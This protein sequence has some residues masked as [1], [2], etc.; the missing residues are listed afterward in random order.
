M[1]CLLENNPF[2]GTLDPEPLRIKQTELYEYVKSNIPES[3]KQANLDIESSVDNER[4]VLAAAIA[5][6]DILLSDCALG[7]TAEQEDYCRKVQAL[8]FSQAALDFVDVF[9]GAAVALDSMLL[10][11]NSTDVI[12]ALRFFVQ[13]RHFKLPCALS[14]MKRALSLMWSSE[15]IIRDEVSS[16]FVDV[17]IAAPCSD[18]QSDLPDQEIAMNLLALTENASASE[19]ASIEE[20]I[21]RLV[22]EM[23]LPRNVF[24][25]LWLIASKKS[26][27]RVSAFKLLSMGAAADRTFLESKSRLKV[28]LD[29]G[30]LESMRNGNDWELANAV[31]LV[32]QHVGRAVVAQND[33]TYIL[34][35]HI[36]DTLCAIVT[37]ESCVDTNDQD[38]LNWFSPAERAIK[39]LFV[40]CPEPEVICDSIILNMSNTMFE[41]KAEKCNA[42]RLARFFHVLGE[43]GLNLLVY[44]ESLIGSVRRA[45]AKRSL[46][47]QLDAEQSKSKAKASL[48]KTSTPK[49]EDAMESELGMDAAVEA[50]N[51]RKLLDIAENEILGRGIISHFSPLLVYVVADES[52]K[53][54]SEILKQASVL[55]LCKFMCVSSSFC[56]KHLDILF[57]VIS[58]GRSADTTIR[59]NTVV[60]MGDLAFRFPNEFEPYTQR[61][62]SC[63]RDSST[64][65]RRHA[66]MVLTHLILNDMVKVK[67]RVSEIA[68][69]L[70]DA[71]PR[72]RD[73]SRLLFHEL[74]KRSNSPIYNLIPDIVSQLGQLSL[75]KEDF[76]YIMAFLL[77]YINKEKQFEMLTE[78]LCQ[79][80]PGCTSISQKADLAFCISQIKMNEK[81]I[82]C[83]SDNF[84]LYKDALADDDVMKSFVGV[85]SKAKKFVKLEMKEFIEEWETKLIETA[86]TGQENEKVQQNAIAARRKQSRQKQ[87]KELQGN[88]GGIYSDE[89]D[90]D[91]SS[92]S[93]DKEHVL[94]PKSTNI[95]S[96]KGSK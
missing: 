24:K 71:D 96:K 78:K 79:R 30:L 19:L 91:I 25:L 27:H 73:M 44:T 58:N 64:R 51:D 89:V 8:Q 13:A 77:S 63:L 57:S 16:A 4:G 32:L 75:A 22:K 54:S 9:E 31:T 11:A 62:Y 83:L 59:A 37:G 94:R 69:C 15:K 85:V 29:E 2:L 67:G 45:N 52:G 55:A 93:V 87:R 80:F 40:I 12:E 88:D 47:T 90:T 34:L 68:V 26:K 72:I 1:T 10:S 76:R 49:E 81:C 74:S 82:K 86:G 56:E 36:V 38:T 66:L 33:P 28:L 17:F 95:R 21:V 20:V 5:E 46:K 50:E 6:A 70:T 65:V 39:A 7:L 60:A 18:R 43:I 48:S 92:Q 3:I 53:F 84:K 35:D 61:L 42:L 14:G 23:R 41:D